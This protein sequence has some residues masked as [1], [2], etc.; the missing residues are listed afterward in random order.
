MSAFIA[1]CVQMNAPPVLND[2]IDQAIELIRQAIAQGATLVVTPE[3]TSGIVYGKDSA[4]RRAS[5]IH[6]EDNHPALIR[7]TQLAAEH[8]VT[9]VIGSLIVRTKGAKKPT[10]RCYVINDK[11]IITHH[12]DKIHLFDAC[13]SATEH[14]AESDFYE[15]GRRAV[16]ASH[17]GHGIGLT[18]C[19]DVRF[20]ALF[21][22]LSACGVL[23][24]TVPAAFTRPTGEAHWHCLLKARA[25]ENA[26][27]ILASAQCG[28]HDGGRT[29]WGHSMIIDPWG[30]CCI[31]AGEDVGVI[32]ALIEPHKQQEALARV[33]VLNHRRTFAAATM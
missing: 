3:N 24:I 31:S 13:V 4:A 8:G 29:T 20:P 14:H 2:S 19:Y 32:T 26:C 16:V 28:T 9:L 25:I 10:N 17:R 33:P 30:D 11:G 15:A 5:L 12:Y 21:Q 1:A 23:M 27:Y 22:S 7:L 18:I 6:D